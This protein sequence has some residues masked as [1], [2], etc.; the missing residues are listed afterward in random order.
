MKTNYYQ[1]RLNYVIKRHVD[2][3]EWLIYMGADIFSGHGLDR[4]EVFKFKMKGGVG[5]LYETGRCN[6]FFNKMA[7]V[8]K[9]E[10]KEPKKC[11]A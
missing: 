8:F 11:V 1:W 6:P 9:N 3:R 10:C 2:F 4:G 5:I 7:K